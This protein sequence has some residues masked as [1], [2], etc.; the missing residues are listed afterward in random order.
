M[1]LKDEPFLVEIVKDALCYV[2]ADAR[3]EARRAFPKARSQV[4]MEYVLPD[5]VESARGHPRD[6]RDPACAP[7]PACRL[8]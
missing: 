7:P 3:A 5:G 4:A 1:N 2:A 6:P 8:T